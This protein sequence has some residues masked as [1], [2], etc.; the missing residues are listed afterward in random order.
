MTH[1][2]TSTWVGNI[3][4]PG[5]TT[6]NDI[7]TFRETVECI[8]QED[9]LNCV[10]AQNVPGWSDIRDVVFNVYLAP[11]TNETLDIENQIYTRT[12][13]WPDKE[14][15]D[16]WFFIKSKLL[17]QDPDDYNGVTFINGFV[18]KI[19]EIGEDI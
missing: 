12:I 1:R 3:D 9:F 6:I 13:D 7:Q 16:K 4:V 17:S 11:I 5:Y 19:Q 14:S 10:D 2:V 18:Y 15:Y 8:S